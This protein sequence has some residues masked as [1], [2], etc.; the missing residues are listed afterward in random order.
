MAQ[1]PATSR[2]LSP[3]INMP[4]TTPR[5]IPLREKREVRGRQIC[6]VHGFSRPWD[7][8]S[9]IQPIV[10]VPKPDAAKP[11]GTTYIG[12]VRI[13]P[14]QN[15]CA[16]DLRC[17][18]PP[19]PTSCPFAAIDPHIPMTNESWGAPHKCPM[20]QRRVNPTRL[21]QPCSPAEC[22]CNCQFNAGSTDII[23]RR[24]ARSKQHQR[25]LLETATL[26]RQ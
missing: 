13:N 3:G 5:R 11:P 17:S 23:Q 19:K 18:W 14:R 24:V 21:C 12:R 8:F 1:E 4:Q 15:R 20:V 9:N 7:S 26:R 2:R 16:G 6:R 25:Q 10:G 22:D